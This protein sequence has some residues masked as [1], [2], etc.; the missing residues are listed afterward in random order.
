MPE[1]SQG[2]K[3]LINAAALTAYFYALFSL[4]FF[5]PLT[6]LGLWFVPADLIFLFSAAAFVFAFFALTALS[7][8]TKTKVFVSTGFITLVACVI[9]F[10]PMI[11]LTWNIRMLGFSVAAKRADPVVRAVERYVEENKTYPDTIESLVPAYLAKIPYGIPKLRVGTNRNGNWMLSADVGSG[12]MNWD[13]FFYHSDHDYSRYSY[14]TK[15]LGDW[16][17]YNE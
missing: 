7:F 14:S 8:S 12:A 3:N 13:Q 9:L 16:A 11:I 4:P 5:G 15:R 17:Y 1:R 6:G 10:I 2:Q